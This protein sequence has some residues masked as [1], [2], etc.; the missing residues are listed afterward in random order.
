MPDWPWLARCMHPCLQPL[1]LQPVKQAGRPRCAGSD[2]ANDLEPRTVS[3]APAQTSAAT[4]IGSCSGGASRAIAVLLSYVRHMG[5]IQDEPCCWIGIVHLAGRFLV[6]TWPRAY[7][8][9]SVLPS[10]SQHLSGG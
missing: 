2:R 6:V 8:P 4:K 7:P 5:Q 1:P 9:T 10:H 3:S